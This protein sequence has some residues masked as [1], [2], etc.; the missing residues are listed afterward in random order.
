ME[1]YIDHIQSCNYCGKEVEMS[2]KHCQCG[3]TSFTVRQKSIQNYQDQISELKQ[4]NKQL[5]KLCEDAVTGIIADII[6]KLEEGKELL[7]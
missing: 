3:G 6:K 7:K 5:K 4:Q 1:K 2:T